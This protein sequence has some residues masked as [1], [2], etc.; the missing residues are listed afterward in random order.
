MPYSITKTIK[1]ASRLGGI[2]LNV[3]GSASVSWDMLDELGGS[4]ESRSRVVAA[5]D[6]PRELTVDQLFEWADA[7]VVTEE[8]AHQAAEAAAIAAKVKP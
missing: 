3:D 4:V 2:S 8:G 5:E 6:V 1:L 7:K